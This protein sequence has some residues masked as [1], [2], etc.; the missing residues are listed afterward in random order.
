MEASA[1]TSVIREEPRDVLRL[2][3]ARL[4]AGEAPGEMEGDKVTLPVKEP[5][6]AIPL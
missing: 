1:T 5:M 6:T 4:G 3:A 2:T